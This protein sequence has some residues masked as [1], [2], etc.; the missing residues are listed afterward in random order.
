MQ[1]LQNLVLRLQHGNCE[2]VPICFV[3][4]QPKFDERCRKK[5]K[6]ENKK[7]KKIKIFAIYR[8]LLK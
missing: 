4:N 1:E 8:S 3:Q 2:D 5:K 7:Y 6:M